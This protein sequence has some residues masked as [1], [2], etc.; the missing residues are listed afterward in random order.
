MKELK[1]E[2]SVCWVDAGLH[3]RPS[4]LRDRIQAELE[5]LP[6]DTEKVILF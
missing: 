5:L 2:S 1:M 6:K 4:L 3:N